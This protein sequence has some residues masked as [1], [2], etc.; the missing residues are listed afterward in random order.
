M[1]TKKLLIVILLLLVIMVFTLIAEQLS[2]L[3]SAIQ[4]EVNVDGG[5]SVRITLIESFINIV[6]N[7]LATPTLTPEPTPTLK[8]TS[9]PTSTPTQ[10]P[11]PTPSPAPTP[12]PIPTPTPTPTPIP[13]PTPT[14]VPLRGWNGV[15][16]EYVNFG[17]YYI[18]TGSTDSILWR[19]L[20]A[21]DS[22]ALLLS[23]YILE[24][25]SFDS[26]G[27]T[28]KNS[29]IYNW[30]NITFFN[31]AFCDEEQAAI[32]SIDPEYGSVFLLGES[33][34]LNSEYG[35]SSADDF[36]DPSRRA[37]ATPHAKQAKVWIDS[38]I[39]T[40]T[41]YT[42]THKYGKNIVQ[43]TASGLVGWAAFDRKDV[44]IRPAIWIDKT[45]IVL[46][47]GKGTMESPYE[48]NDEW[49]NP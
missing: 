30:L 2:D 43:I 21:S 45:K 16:Y 40:S 42:S 49:S 4:S 47:S 29:E 34:Y 1:K 13:T 38:E 41:Y 48:K 31:Q 14:P 17:Q 18:N 8:P 46:N 22:K 24:A 9:A 19:V 39:H 36:P 35:F 33:D 37:F 28:W 44:G 6:S 7:R 23:E 32:L 10:S 5:V 27:T 11:V 20:Y 15:D 25:R 26:N 3:T 12:S